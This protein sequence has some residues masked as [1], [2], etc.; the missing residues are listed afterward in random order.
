M[1]GSLLLLLPAASL[2]QHWPGDLASYTNKFPSRKGTKVNLIS[3]RLPPP[4][5]K[6]SGSGQHVSAISSHSAGMPLEGYG[7]TVQDRERRHPSAPLTARACPPCEPGQGDLLKTSPGCSRGAKMCQSSQDSHCGVCRVLCS[8]R[9]AT[10]S[11]Q[12]NLLL[13]NLKVSGVALFG[14][15]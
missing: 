1:G 5:K 9:E 10:Y 3:S 2:L 4:R 11:L 12:I 6:R 8:I 15:L 7:N 14:D 13:C